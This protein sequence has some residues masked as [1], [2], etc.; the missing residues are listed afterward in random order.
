MKKRQG[1]VIRLSEQ[2]QAS[3]NGQEQQRALSH[4]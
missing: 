3:D 4:R 2:Q 1:P